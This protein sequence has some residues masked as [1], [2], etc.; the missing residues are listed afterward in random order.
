MI[1]NLSASNASR[2]RTSIS[3]GAAAVPRCMYR[4]C[5]EMEWAL[6]SICN[7]LENSSVA[8]S[9][10]VRARLTGSLRIPVEKNSTDC[11]E[12]QGA[13]A[14]TSVYAAELSLDGNNEGL[15]LY[16]TGV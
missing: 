1:R 9:L 4:S 11:G 14:A 6:S 13:S 15:V 10:D 16:A 3:N 7:L 5:G 8:Q 2:R 12:L